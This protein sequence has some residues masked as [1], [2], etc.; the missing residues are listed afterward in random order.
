MAAWPGWCSFCMRPAS[1]SS[2]KRTSD[3]HLSGCPI[4]HSR[5]PLEALV[6]D[7]A[8]R[9]LMALVGSGRPDTAR[10]AITLSETVEARQGKQPRQPL[11]NLNY[12]KKV[13][14]LS[15]PGRSC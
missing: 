11:K 8:G 12:L 10:L 3:A 9:E 4:C 5:I 7:E 1:L 2:A 13:W 15:R 14:N 6:Q